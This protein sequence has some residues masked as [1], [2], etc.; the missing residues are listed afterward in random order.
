MLGV[1][2]SIGA[3]NAEELEAQDAERETALENLQGIQRRA[4][5]K[6]E[7]AEATG[8]LNTAYAASGVDLSWGTAA[9]ARQDAFRDA[10]LALTA[11]AG[12]QEVRQSR[13]AERAANYRAGAKR[14]RAAGI[15]NGLTGAIGGASPLLQRG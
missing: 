6:R 9:A 1:V 8:A 4:S 13:L 10:D 15:L 2:A 14:A 5:I 7:L 12:T 3:G 11:D